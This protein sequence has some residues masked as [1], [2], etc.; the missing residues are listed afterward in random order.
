LIEN[1]VLTGGHIYGSENGENSG[2]T[3]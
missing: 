1:N 3:R 2:D